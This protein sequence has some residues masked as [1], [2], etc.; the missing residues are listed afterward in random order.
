MKGV[1][2]GE[3]GFLLGLF[4]SLINYKNIEATKKQLSCGARKQNL[5]QKEVTTGNNYINSISSLPEWT[6]D[7][8]ERYHKDRNIWYTAPFSLSSSIGSYQ[9]FI[10]LTSIQPFH[11]S[12]EIKTDIFGIFL[13]SVIGMKRCRNHESSTGLSAFREVLKTSARSQFYH[14]KL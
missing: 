1:D 12:T 3:T 9:R 8:Q 10:G 4:A 7:F 6:W 2:E 11:L 13:N 5:S 14:K